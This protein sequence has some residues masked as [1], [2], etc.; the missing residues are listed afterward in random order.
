MQNLHRST[1]LLSL[2]VT[3]F[4]IRFTLSTKALLLLPTSFSVRTL[5]RCLDLLQTIVS[6]HSLYFLH[7]PTSIA[8]SSKQQ[9]SHPQFSR[10]VSIPRGSR[11]TRVAERF[12]RSLVNE[13]LHR[14]SHILGI[15]LVCKS[16]RFALS[17]LLALSAWHI[18]SAGTG[19]R[20]LR[21]TGYES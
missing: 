9:L 18:G 14:L 7:T 5:R 1:L 11:S 20:W 12:Q 3:T 10:I 8:P 16:V 15:F 2:T 6:F 13:V 4:L 17:G 19:S 21:G